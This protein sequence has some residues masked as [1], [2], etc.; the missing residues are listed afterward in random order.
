[1][2][3]SLLLASASTSGATTHL[4]RLEYETKE[5]SSDGSSGSSRGNNAL[6]ER[7]VAVR[8][9]GIELEYDLSPDAIAQDRAR[10]WA[11]PARV[12][13]AADETLTLLNV[14]EVAARQDRWMTSA[15]LPRSACGRWYFT[16]NAFRIECDPQSVLATIKGYRV[17]SE[18]V[19][20]GQSYRLPEAAA[21]AP[22]VAE[23]DNNGVVRLVAVMSLDP[24]TVQKA[25]AE[26]DVVVGEMTGE[27]VQ[28]GE[29]LARRAR[30]TISGTIAVMFTTP[31]PGTKKRTKVVTIVTQTPDRTTETSVA[32]EHVTR[33]P[34]ASDRIATPVATSAPRS[35]PP[36]P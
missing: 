2:L 30:E 13:V 1:L 26:S 15:K 23:T 17:A 19:A 36:P 34:L 31:S 10:E 24:S 20:E 8:D 27:P 7:F 25:R 12:L 16:W 35:I 3:L 29:A 11:F 33:T 4:L 18:R 21:P 14:E 9:A 22:L 6:I 28:R 5:T 32:T